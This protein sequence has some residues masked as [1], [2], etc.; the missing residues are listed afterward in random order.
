MPLLTLVWAMNGFTEQGLYCRCLTVSYLIRFEAFQNEKFTLSNVLVSKFKKESLP[1]LHRRQKF[2]KMTLEDKKGLF[3]FFL[4]LSGTSCL[5][6]LLE[7]L[8]GS[9]REALFAYHIHRS[10]WNQEKNGT[11]NKFQE[12]YLIVSSCFMSYCPYST[13]GMCTVRTCT[14]VYALFP[15]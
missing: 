9:T 4:L 2:F 15:Y 14:A 5:V 11:L 12:L 8:V 1:L 13:Y 6:F 7:L 10:I 3:V